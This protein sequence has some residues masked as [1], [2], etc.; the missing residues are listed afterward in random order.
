MPNQTKLTAQQLNSISKQ[1]DDVADGV[2]GERNRLT[3]EI[4]A[5]VGGNRGD[6][7]RGLQ[8]VH[9]DW[10]A[11]CQQ[12]ENKLREMAAMIRTSAS[13][14]QASDADIAGRVRRAGTDSASASGLSGFLGNG[15]GQ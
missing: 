11:R 7:I 9:T 8:D 13:Q 1:H 10:D 3:A 12:V 4:S 14:Y 15:A 5:L 2:R 6:M